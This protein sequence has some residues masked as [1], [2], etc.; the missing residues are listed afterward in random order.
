[1]ISLQTPSALFLIV[2]NTDSLNQLQTLASLYI[3]VLCLN[4]QTTSKNLFHLRRIQQKE[5][6][7]KSRQ[8]T[9]EPNWVPGG[10]FT[11]HSQILVGCQTLNDNT[12]PLFWFFTFL[13]WSFYTNL[14]LSYFCETLAGINFH[15]SFFKCL[16]L[17]GNYHVCLVFSSEWSITRD[18]S[19]WPVKTREISYVSP[20]YTV[21]NKVFMSPDVLIVLSW[22]YDRITPLKN[23]FRNE[24][25]TTNWCP[26]DLSQQKFNKSGKK[27]KY[28]L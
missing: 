10:W 12:G 15:P 3:K 16:D 11:K 9:M 21:Y 4:I 8:L 18:L 7:S 28:F 19:T 23:S 20:T 22:A 1:M 5:D 27:R 14:G 17:S 2:P 6:K 24:I 26:S 13:G 25:S